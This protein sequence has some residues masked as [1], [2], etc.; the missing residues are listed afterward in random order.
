MPTA[1]V[2]RVRALASAPT[3]IRDGSGGIPALDT[4]TVAPPTMPLFPFKLSADKIAKIKHDVLARVEQD[5]LEG[6][7]QSAQPLLKV[8]GRPE[9]ARALSDL[10][11]RGAF[12]AKD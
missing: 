12:A 11:R 2:L 1:R 5:D 7:W 6:A 9:A 10:T 8:A 3:L 4:G